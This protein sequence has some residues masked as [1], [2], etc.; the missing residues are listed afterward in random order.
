MLT[1][2][3]FLKNKRAEP[4]PKEIVGVERETSPAAKRTKTD[5]YLAHTHDGHIYQWKLSKPPIV[6]MVLNPKE[7]D[8]FW[9]PGDDDK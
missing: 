2:K 7:H 9:K 1:L 4:H 3:E 8:V 5:F 6:G